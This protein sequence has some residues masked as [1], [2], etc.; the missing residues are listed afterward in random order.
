MFVQ[1]SVEFK[2]NLNAKNEN[3]DT[4]F[5][6]ACYNDDSKIVEMLV[7]KSAEFNIDLNTINEDGKAGFYYFQGHMKTVNILI[8]ME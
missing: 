5:H 8:D 1:K 7:Q 6:F 4:G 2:I 3:G